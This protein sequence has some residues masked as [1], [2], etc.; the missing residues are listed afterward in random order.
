MASFSPFEDCTARLW[1]GERLVVVKSPLRSL[2][3]T[4]GFERYRLLTTIDA[5]YLALRIIQC[6]GLN[7]G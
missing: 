1:N 3:L 5:A 6:D 2:T 7:L 4:G